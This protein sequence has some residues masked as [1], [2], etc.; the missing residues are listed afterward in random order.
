MAGAKQIKVTPARATL[1][2]AGKARMRVKLPAK[3]RLAV[4]GGR[5]VVVRLKLKARLTTRTVTSSR[6]VRVRAARA[7]R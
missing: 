5:T 2:K 4:A 3:A 6:T 7:S 1:R